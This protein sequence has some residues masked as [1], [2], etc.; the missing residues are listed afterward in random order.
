MDVN[1]LSALPPDEQKRLLMKKL[2]AQLSIAADD[3]HH[4]RM[5]MAASAQLP[6]P[7]YELL[8]KGVSNEYHYLL[9]LAKQVQRNKKPEE[10]AKMMKD[11]AW[12]THRLPSIG[13]LLESRLIVQC[14]PDESTLLRRIRRL[15]DNIKQAIQMIQMWRRV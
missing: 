13:E 7:G 8:L 11:I 14:H 4:V 3:V 5:L 9:R 2:V 15:R 12:R 10:Q 1:N 6:A